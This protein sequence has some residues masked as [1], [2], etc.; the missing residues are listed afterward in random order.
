MVREHLT[1]GQLM[2]LVTLTFAVI[3]M[4]IP[5]PV[6]AGPIRDASVYDRVINRV[7]ITYQKE[8]WEGETYMVIVGQVESSPNRPAIT[9]VSLG[10]ACFKETPHG[11]TKPSECN[12]CHERK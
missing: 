2:L 8:C 1:F 3:W 11:K 6:D 10:T 7:G 9:A 12:P 5:E 4:A